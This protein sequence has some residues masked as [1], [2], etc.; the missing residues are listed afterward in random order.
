MLFLE[1]VIDVACAAKQA[2]DQSAEADRRCVELAE[3]AR[4]A[5]DQAASVRDLAASLTLTA[6]SVARMAL[7]VCRYHSY[8]QA[9]EETF[10]ITHRQPPI[11]Y[12]TFLSLID[13]S[14]QT[15]GS[16]TGSGSFTDTAAQRGAGSFLGTCSEVDE[17]T[18]SYEHD[19]RADTDNYP[20]H[21]QS[22]PV[23][24]VC[25]ESASTDEMA[26][27]TA[28]ESRRFAVGAECLSSFFHSVSVPTMYDAQS[29]S[30]VLYNVFV[31]YQYS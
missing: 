31:Q 20:A 17:M 15:V 11:D 4:R 21:N 1:Q 6:S 12:E 27:L 13:N 7:D 14:K 23:N 25:E 2:V 24:H 30:A 29:L 16:A 8:Q 10:G 3:L 22:N 9:F 5:A 28:G 18:L 19:R 26:Q